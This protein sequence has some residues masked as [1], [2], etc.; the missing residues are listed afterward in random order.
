MIDALFTDSDYVAAKKML[1]VTVLRHQA[2]AS[3]LANVETPNYKRLDVS[4]PLKPIAPGRRR[5]KFREIA[6]CNR[7]LAVDNGAISGPSPTGTRCNWRRR[8]SNSTKTR[9]K[10]RAGNAIGQRLP[11]PAAHGHHRQS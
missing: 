8:C 9:W 7:Q 1:D 11:G 3:N 2:I 5:P 10:T 6:N 4:P